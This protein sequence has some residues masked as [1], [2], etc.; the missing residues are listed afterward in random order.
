M[1]WLLEDFQNSA[2]WSFINEILGESA[3]VLSRCFRFVLI[4]SFLTIRAQSYAAC[5]VIEHT[6]GNY[7]QLGEN[8]FLPE[9][10]TPG[11][12]D[13]IADRSTADDFEEAPLISF[14]STGR[15]MFSKSF[16]SE[17]LANE[18]LPKSYISKFLKIPRVTAFTFF[19][20]GRSPG[21]I[22]GSDGICSGTGEDS[23]ILTYYVSSQL[24][25]S[26]VSTT[27]SAKIAKWFASSR[28]GKV[29]EGYVYVMHVSGAFYDYL[30]PE[31]VHYAPILKEKR[32]YYDREQIARTL[33]KK[34]LEGPILYS[35]FLQ[36]ELAVYRGINWNRFVAYRRVGTDGKFKGPVYFRKNFSK[37]ASEPYQE[38]KCYLSG[39]AIDECSHHGTH[40][41]KAHEPV[42]E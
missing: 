42:N 26:Y 19:G 33:H 24:G 29:R 38:I 9:D 1:G 30:L 27:R 31:K 32:N 7:R 22:Q 15:M 2:S 37:R 3:M 35:P 13:Q 28:F 20:S 34:I 17:K 14:P 41:E 25:G 21:S 16:F 18:G 6:T 4:T 11:Y 12:E 39:G 36:E 40:H 23:D 5:P 8:E 10:P